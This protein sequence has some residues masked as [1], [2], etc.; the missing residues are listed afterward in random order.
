M[1]KGGYT[2]VDCTGFDFSN[3]GTVSGIYEKMTTAFKAGKF[4]LCANMKNGNAHFTPI[5]AFLATET[6]GNATVIVLT[7]MNIPYR[8]S[9]DDSIS[10]S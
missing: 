10:Q 6:V 2:L 7:V 5:P 4:V 1:L 3:L 9:A 8:I